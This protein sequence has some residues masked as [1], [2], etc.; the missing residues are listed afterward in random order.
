MGRL[1]VFG[2]VPRSVGAALHLDDDVAPAL[3]TTATR[4]DCHAVKQAAFCAAVRRLEAGGLVT[5]STVDG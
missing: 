3:R 2:S 4:G 5:S 1:A